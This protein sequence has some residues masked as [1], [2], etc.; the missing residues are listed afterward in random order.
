MKALI[1]L[2]APEVSFAIGC[3]KA[4]AGGDLQEVL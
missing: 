2:L 4:L 3:I 1:S